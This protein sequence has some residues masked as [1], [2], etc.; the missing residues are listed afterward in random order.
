[1]NN[2][3]GNIRQDGLEG[4]AARSHF[5]RCFRQLYETVVI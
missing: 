2:R 3:N 4:S 5:P 1:M